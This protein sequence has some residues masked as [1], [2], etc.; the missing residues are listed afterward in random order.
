MRAP[1]KRPTPAALRVGN[2]AGLTAL[3]VAT[4]RTLGDDDRHRLPR[5]RRDADLEAVV[6]EILEPAL[7]E[8]PCLVAFS[9]GRESSWL[10][11]AAVAAARRRGHPDPIPATIRYADTSARQAA[12]QERVVTYLELRDWERVEIED[13]L[14]IVGPYARRAVERAGVLFPATAYAMLPLLDRAHGGWLLSGGGLTDFFLYWR[15]A[16]LA[17]VL[18]GRRR[19]RRRDLREAALASI[20]PRGRALL[21]GRR[22]SEPAPWLR[23][24][25]MLEVQAHLRDRLAR[26]PVGFAAAIARQSSHRCNEAM[27]S[28]F[29][30]LAATVD[31]RMLMPFREDR[32]LGALAS[33]GGR[34]GLGDRAELLARLAGHLL[35]ARLL[36]GSDAEDRGRPFVGE[37]ARAFV[38]TWSGG[39]VD[40][41][42]VDT[43]ALREAW[44][45]GPF[46]W[47]SLNLLQLA[48]AHA[49][50]ASEVGV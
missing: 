17:D 23:R 3:E 29:D 46:P 47:G 32:Y 7:A 28:S 43:D 11:A 19:P 21:L 1:Q 40:D 49:T 6:D 27:R 36:R 39:G 2:P 41:E 25:A 4:A 12:H 10:L 14:D 16:R 42:I 44:V 8:P 48:F 9:G 37:A 13:E 34:R 33:V 31:A 45:T 22:L 20:P 24:D 35:P 18:T 50:A 26:V 15:W 30:A 5:F 38:A